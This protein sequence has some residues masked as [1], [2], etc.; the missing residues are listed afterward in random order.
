MGRPQLPVWLLVKSP[1]LQKV[2]N[3]NN[4][5]IIIIII[6]ITGFIIGNSNWTKWSII[7]GEIGPAQ[8]TRPI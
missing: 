7:Q 2:I 6:I 3:Y 8:S 4:F 5:I 1:P